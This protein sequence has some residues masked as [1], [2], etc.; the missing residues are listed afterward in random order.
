MNVVAVFFCQVAELFCRAAVPFG[1]KVE[2]E[3]KI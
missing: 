2:N 3:A 1:Q